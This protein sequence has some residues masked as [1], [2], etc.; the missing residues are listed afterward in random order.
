MVRSR[1]GDEVFYTIDWGS[2]KQ[3]RVKNLSYG[4]EI[5]EFLDA[6]DRGYGLMESI[7]VIHNENS[8]SYVIHME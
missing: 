8:I 7:P 3:R 2:N 1:T 6:D 4:A 5:L